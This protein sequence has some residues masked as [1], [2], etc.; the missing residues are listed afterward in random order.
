MKKY[1]PV[2]I[3]TLL[4]V[5]FS[6]KKEDQ[7]STEQKTKDLLYFYEAMEANY[8]YFEVAK[9]KNGIDWLAQKEN[10]LERVRSTSSDSA[11]FSELKSIMYELKDGHADFS[12]TPM[13]EDYLALYKEIAED[14]PRYKV[15]VET[16]ESSR[17]DIEYWGNLI[18]KKPKEKSTGNTPKKKIRQYKDTIMPDKKI[19]IMTI[20]S[21]EN[22][23]ILVDKPKIE[24]F[25]SHLK[26]I[27]NLIIDIQGNGGGSTHYWST[28]IVPRLI[29]DSLTF[30]SYFAIK[31]GDIN[32]R[33]YSDIFDSSDQVDKNDP[34]YHKMHSDYLNGNY[35]LFKESEKIGPDNPITFNGNIYLLVDKNVFSSAEGFAFFCK[36]TGWAKV[37]G[38][39]T[40][41]DGVGSDPVFIQLPES[42]LIARIPVTAG[43]NADGNI[44]SETGTM[45]D[46]IIEGKDMEERL[47]NL[48]KILTN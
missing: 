6:C 23:L 46:I 12:V 43:F 36:T 7:L 27:E 1:C 38:Q 3:L 32:K 20:P 8:P 26:G 18:N 4:L 16:I 19:A 13:W 28:M 30:S 37:V 29:N 9:R 25:F 22:E 21:I 40:R 34:F 48:I 24:K 2:L 14:Y 33:F 5:S 41:G 42:R 45:P 15:W 10:Y 44:N 47:N 39:P 17:P 35:Y 31:N 11:Y